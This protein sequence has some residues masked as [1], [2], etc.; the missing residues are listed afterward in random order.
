MAR[1]K[2]TAAHRGFLLT[3]L[4]DLLLLFPSQEAAAEQLT[5]TLPVASGSSLQSSPNRTSSDQ[6]PQ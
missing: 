1:V 6:L 4:L 3:C 5:L 2:A